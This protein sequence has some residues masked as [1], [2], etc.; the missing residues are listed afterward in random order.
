MPLVSV[1]MPIYNGRRFLGR[2]LDSLQ[3]QEFT[4]FEIVVTDD[5]STDGCA[6]IVRSYDDPRIRLYRNDVRIGIPGNWNVALSK[7]CGRFI[8]FLHQDDILYAHCLGAMVEALSKHSGAGFVFGA[9]ELIE[10]DGLQSKRFHPHLHDCRKI[11]RDRGE[12]RE[13]NPGREL[14]AACI[15]RGGLFSNYIGEP[16]F[17][18]F[19][20]EIAAR[21]GFFD[22]RLLQNA[23][24]DYWYR[25]LLVTDAISIDK[26]VGAFRLH[27]GGESSAGLN[28]IARLRYVWEETV[29]ID[30]LISAAE[31]EG[32]D[33]ILRLLRRRKRRFV[34]YRARALLEHRLGR[35]RTG[36]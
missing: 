32:A 18:M 4:D 13:F 11:L 25:C 31:R 28:L 2:A 19:D 30:N 14:L 17:V 10:H 8:K 6:D 26:P 1:C 21:V 12:I 7:A 23:D 15:R 27:R 22:H 24:Y 20:A 35:F 29:V 33:E 5:A 9:R 3:A 34:T 16:S 36:G